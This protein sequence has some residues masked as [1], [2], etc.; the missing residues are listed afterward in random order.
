MA[1]KKRG[2]TKKEKALANELMMDLSCEPMSCKKVHGC[3]IL[4]EGFDCGTFSDE[5]RA[6]KKPKS[7]ISLPCPTQVRCQ[8][9]KCGKVT[10]GSLKSSPQ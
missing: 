9:V 2:V 5:R 4:C 3:A 10:C 7:A 6:H 8:E 1:V